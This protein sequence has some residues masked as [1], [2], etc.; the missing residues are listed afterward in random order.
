MTALVL[1]LT[2]IAGTISTVYF[3]FQIGELGW[4]PFLGSLVGTAVLSLLA[5]I[6]ENSAATLQNS[7]TAVNQLNMV[8]QQ[9][10]DLQ[11]RRQ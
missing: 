3:F 10:T 9:L 2:L 1:V 7:V 5:K 4:M 11:S 6:W 8:T